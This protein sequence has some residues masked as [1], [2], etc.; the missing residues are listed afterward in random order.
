MTK[1]T[2]RRWPES[3]PPRNLVA[4]PSRLQGQALTYPLM[5]QL[6][7]P[8]FATASDLNRAGI[9]VPPAAPQQMLR[10]IEHPVTERDLK[11]AAVRAKAEGRPSGH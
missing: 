6:T 2:G 8:N 5:G 9:A 4:T 10:G 7:A 11:Q 3:W 1:P